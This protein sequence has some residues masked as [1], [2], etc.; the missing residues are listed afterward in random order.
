MDSVYFT[1]IDIVLILTF[2]RNKKT[3]VFILFLVFSREFVPIRKV[4]GWIL[5]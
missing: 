4:A 1:S 2:K 5:Q 3:L